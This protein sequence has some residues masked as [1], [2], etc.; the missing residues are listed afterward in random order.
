[1]KEALKTAD[2]K[3]LVDD[4]DNAR[5]QQLHQAHSHMVVFKKGR[6]G[7][8]PHHMSH[9]KIHQDQ[10]KSHRSQQP[11]LQDRRCPV[12]QGFL[13]FRNPCRQT[14]PFPG[15]AGAPDPGAI[16]GIFHSRNNLFR[17]SSPFYA[18]GIGQQTD[19]AVR[20]ARYLPHRFFN[21]GLAGS[22][23]HARYC[24]LFHLSSLFSDRKNL[25]SSIWEGSSA[26]HPVSPHGLPVRLP[27]HRSGYDWPAVFY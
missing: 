16:A 26:A 19:T 13:F 11:F 7:P 12:P 4:H 27:R 8:V 17:G 14:A 2:K 20:H 9:G 18:H 1:M 22:A 23:A 15:I 10:Q 24:I 6:Q 21:T 25:I 5:Q 3:F